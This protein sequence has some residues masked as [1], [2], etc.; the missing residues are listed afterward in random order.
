MRRAA[1]K[2]ANQAA[3][4]QVF[5]AAGFSVADTSALGNGFVDLVVG[6]CGVN[7]LI[8]VKDGAK[9]PSDRRLTPK[10]EA[11]HA[12]WRGPIAVVETVDGALELVKTLRRKHAAQEAD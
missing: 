11:F 3:I 9:S 1:R 2:D 5:Q 4:E 12:G 10:E 8:E 7:L 6:G